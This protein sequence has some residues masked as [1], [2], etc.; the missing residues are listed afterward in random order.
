MPQPLS[1]KDT[2]LFRQVVRHC[3]SRQNKKGI[4]LADQIL[5]KNPNHGDTQAMKALILSNMGQ[6]EEAF[7]L[8]KT[9]LKNDMKSNVCWHVYGLLWRA[10]K[11][12]EE[13]LK[14]Y[15]FALKLEPGSTAIQRDLALLQ[16]QMRDWQG[17]IQSRTAMLQLRPSLRQNWTAL[18]IAYHLAGDYKEAENVLTTYED[19]LKTPPPRTDMEHSEAVL[20]KNTIIAESGDVERALEHLN[21]VGKRCLD[22]LAVME[23]RADYLLRL[24][25]NE[26]AKKAYTKLL[27]RNPE[28]SS[29]YEGLIKASGVDEKDH[30]ALKAIF[31][32]WVEKNPRGDAPRRL[33]LDFLEG[34]DF[35]AAADAYLT[36]M[37]Q[38]AIPSTFAN[39]K[40]LYID[41]TK[42]DIVQDIV[43][44]Y[45]AKLSPPE[46]SEEPKE[47]IYKHYGDLAKAAE[48]MEE[49][50]KLDPKD[51][52][53]NTKAAKYQLRNNDNESALDNVS[54]FTRNDISG[55]PIGDF[56]E[57]QCTWYLTE[58]GEAYLRQKKLGLALKRLTQVMNIFDTWAEDQFDF[59]NFSL[60]KGMIRAYV[61]MIR[62]EDHLRDHPFYVRAAKSLVKAYILLKDEPN[63]AFGP[64]GINP[65]E[66]LSEADKKKAAKKARKEK[67]KAEAEAAAKK[68]AAATAKNSDDE[69]KK[70]DDDP[71]GEKL[72]ETK[73]PMGDAMKYLTPL[74]KLTPKDIEVQSLAYEIYM[75]QDKPLL[76]FKCLQAAHAVDPEHPTVHVQTA[77]LHKY[78]QSPSSTLPEPIINLVKTQFATLL[79]SSVD[80]NQWNEEYITKHASS[81][82]HLQAGLQVRQLIA[83]GDEVKAKNEQQLIESLEVSQLEDAIRGLRLFDEWKSSGDAKEKYIEKAT[84]R[85]EHASAFRG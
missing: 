22:T 80:L 5:K 3:E 39:I 10:E 61:D 25:R 34:D 6:T 84:Q 53:I 66:N 57:M 40:T 29:Y 76:A 18:A 82:A 31:D 26:E 48:V 79:P 73:D 30:K 13:A 17:Y 69:V 85:W 68:A 62:W 81:P 1:S 45:A 50:R 70:V 59:H 83:P 14:A 12:F 65:N 46:K 58:D 52:Y 42:R 77:K 9:A 33:P 37:L 75:R 35:R 27:D 24:G 11:N 67:E 78:L 36:R 16:A 19:T 51:R 2:A 47:T 15:K 20:Y 44:G 43:E 32:E 54:K 71:N 72:V 63:L 38:K 74:L 8:C 23:M 41:T 49:A 4:K 60:R 56:L 21:K 64:E 7:A 55:G 28:N